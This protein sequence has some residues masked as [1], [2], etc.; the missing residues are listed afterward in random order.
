MGTTDAI[1]HGILDAALKIGSFAFRSYVETLAGAPSPGSS[2]L[3]NDTAAD[4]I[5]ANATSLVL[6]GVRG[7]DADLNAASEDADATARSRVH[8]L[9]ESAFV[10]CHLASNVASSRKWQC[11]TDTTRYT[12]T[13]IEGL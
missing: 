9:D 2:A 11:R 6:D 8:S 3:R 5:V 7:D 13:E 4:L 10:S 12:R 1:V